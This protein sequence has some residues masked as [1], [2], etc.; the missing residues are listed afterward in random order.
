MLSLETVEHQLSS[1]GLVI[2]PHSSIHPSGISWHLNR[3][4]VV[5]PC[6][7]NGLKWWVLNEQLDEMEKVATSLIAKKD[8]P[9]W[10]EQILN[11]LQERNVVIPQNVIS[12]EVYFHCPISTKL[13][14]PPTLRRPLNQPIL[15]PHISYTPLRHI[16][17]GKKDRRLENSIAEGTVLRIQEPF[18]QIVNIFHLV[19][20]AKT[21]FEEMSLAN[22]PLHSL[23]R[24]TAHL[25][26]A[27]G[28][29]IDAAPSAKLV[30]AYSRRDETIAESFAQNRYA[31]LPM[32]FHPFTL[33]AL[34]RY[35]RE[36]VAE[37]W[38]EAHCE[39]V[40]L[41]M[42]T[43][44]EPVARYFHRQLAPQVSRWVRSAHKP[45]CTYSVKYRPGSILERHTDRDV[46]NRSISFLLDARPKPTRQTTWPLY[47]E[48]PGKPKPRRAA[49]RMLPGEGV[50]FDGRTLPHYRYAQPAGH[51]SQ[52]I[53]FF[54]VPE[55]FTG[56]LN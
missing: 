14:L 1:L 31:R 28:L 4:V 44:N 18:T 3:S 5:S 2:N 49:I 42:R 34:Q 29:I 39:Q 52:N 17:G 23:P 25:F 51:T 11:R 8:V 19:G 12:R 35:Y 47:F 54:Y 7:S 40:Y 56:N 20:E 38:M 22:R 48:L 6:R 50:L 21:A 46:A 13:R 55:E 16:S 45:S 30:Q 33:K 32:L 43:H 26:E 41:R 24:P 37:G 9:F 36:L 15:N 53:F 27:M 10:N